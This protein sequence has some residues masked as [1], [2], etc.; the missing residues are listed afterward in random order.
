LQAERDL[1][2]YDTQLG[3]IHATAHTADLLQA[4]AASPMMTS[5]EEHNILSAIAARLSSAPQVYTQGEQDRLAQAV[6]V[7]VRRP[8]CKTNVFENWLSQ[9]RQEDRNVWQ[10]PL[11]PA[12][13]ATYQNHTYTL[14]AVAVHLELEPESE[15]ITSARRQVLEIL[16]T[17]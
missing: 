9:L 12:S 13:L 2:G 4:L 5:E 17:R 1:R 6:V 8:D 14:Q 16:R 15:K 11:T 7:V 3:W 10:Q